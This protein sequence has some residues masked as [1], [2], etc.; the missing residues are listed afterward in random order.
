MCTVAPQFSV[1]GNYTALS[2]TI[3]DA[4]LPNLR[5]TGRADAQGVPLR[6]VAADRAG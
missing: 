1:G 3:R 4:L 6:R 5:P 2:R